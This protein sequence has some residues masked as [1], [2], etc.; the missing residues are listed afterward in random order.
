[1]IKV[2][3]FGRSRDHRGLAR[4]DRPLRQ[5]ADGPSCPA[6][7]AARGGRRL[8]PDVMGDGRMRLYV[9]LAGSKLAHP[10]DILHPILPL[11]GYESSRFVT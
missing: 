3:R 10:L 8:G 1:M 9:R 11:R 6:P 2:G 5:I 4:P 7:R